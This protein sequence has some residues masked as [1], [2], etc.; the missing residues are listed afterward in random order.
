MGLYRGGLG[1]IVNKGMNITVRSAAVILSLQVA[2]CTEAGMKDGNEVNW[3]NLTDFETGDGQFNETLNRKVLSEKLAAA[4]DYAP[5][6]QMNCG[7]FSIDVR[8][9][10][11]ARRG[12]EFSD[13]SG[14]PDGFAMIVTAPQVSMIGFSFGS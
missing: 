1:Y 4:L 9:T 2:A 10:K 5:I 13:T 14:K 12:N 11:I 8:A 7:P 6:Q 3:K